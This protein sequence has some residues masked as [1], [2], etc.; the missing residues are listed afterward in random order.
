[1]NHRIRKWN[2]N[3]A[4]SREIHRIF[5]NVFPRLPLRKPEVFHQMISQKVRG[6]EDGMSI[7]EWNDKIAGFAGVFEMDNPTKL[8]L[9]G[10]VRPPFERQGIGRDLMTRTI[11]WAK[12]RQYV[13]LHTMYFES[14]RRSGL[15]LK[16]A[17]FVV[18]DRIFWSHW[19]CAHTMRPE[20]IRKANRVQ[21]TGVRL[22]SGS[23]FEQVRP[24]WDRCWW[25]LMMQALQD[26]P[27]EVPFENV[28][29]DKWRPFLEPPFCQRANT[30]VA[31]KGQELIGL[32]ML[33]TPEGETVNINH[34][35]VRPEY[36]RQGI[37]TALKVA[38]I[39][40]AKE[41]DM[42]F[43]QT[44]NHQRNPMAALNQAFGF[45]RVATQIETRRLL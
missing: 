26:V 16:N 2:Q 4:D 12:Q 3:L 20:V 33:D 9:I 17:G 19:D 44:Q 13:E 25:R 27:S 22:I 21:Q 7:A 29:F 1:M 43:V 28:P 32:L 36:R 5:M 24:D 37:S 41:L 8:R 23:D 34:T 42:R 39:E 45:V 6:L 10:G 38:A 35:S 11:H 14:Q 40:R 30:V 18:Q 15:F 31:L